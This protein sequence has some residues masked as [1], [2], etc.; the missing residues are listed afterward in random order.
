MAGQSGCNGPGAATGPNFIAKFEI[1]DEPS[2]LTLESSH[3][4]TSPDAEY[5]A[6]MLIE[7]EGEAAE[8]AGGEAA[9]GAMQVDT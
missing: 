5:N 6:W 2:T 1:D 3:Y 9:V 8:A 7:P 4:D